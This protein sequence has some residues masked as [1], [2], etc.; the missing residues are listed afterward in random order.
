MPWRLVLLWLC[1]A[2]LP[3]RGW[4]GVAMPAPAAAAPAAAVQEAAA[5]PCHGAAA[6][7]NLQEEFHEHR[8]G[9][10]AHADAAASMQPGAGTCALCD[11]CHGAVAPPVLAFE[12]F[13][14]MN[15][16]APPAWE[17]RSPGRLATH[18]LFRPPRA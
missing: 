3:L 5:R 7:E 12:G 11:I 18:E 17:P 4:A 9:A 15:P 6:V 10:T 16:G 1:I 14:P 13:A 2:L 8:H